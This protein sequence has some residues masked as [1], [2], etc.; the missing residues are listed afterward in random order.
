MSSTP[1]GRSD[2]DSSAMKKP[3]A[4]GNGGGTMNN[5]MQPSAN[6]NGTSTLGGPAGKM[7]DPANK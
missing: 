6:P 5:N 1:T 7:A 2:S 4:T 3:G